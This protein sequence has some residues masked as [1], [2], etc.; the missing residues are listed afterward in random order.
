MLPPTWIALGDKD[1]R[2]GTDAA[3]R[4]AGSSRGKVTLLVRVCEGHTTPPETPGWV[5]NGFSG[6]S[7]A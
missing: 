2:V 6:N 1:D 4:F 3:R 5:R 7:A